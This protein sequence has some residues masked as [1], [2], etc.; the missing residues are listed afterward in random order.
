M[1]K[2]NEVINIKDRLDIEFICDNKNYKFYFQVSEFRGVMIEIEV[3]VPMKTLHSKMYKIF[4]TI[5]S[6]LV[7][8]KEYIIETCS[9]SVELFANYKF[10]YTL[11][12]KERQTQ[13]SKVIVF[14]DGTVFGGEVTFYKQ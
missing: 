6:S 8:K 10:V 4:Y 9:F 13:V 1:H 5:T 2:K 7:F 14:S 11:L 3:N 12:N